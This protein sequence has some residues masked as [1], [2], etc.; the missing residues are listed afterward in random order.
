[1]CSV[2]FSSWSPPQTWNH[3]PPVVFSPGMAILVWR[4]CCWNSAVIRTLRI[5]SLKRIL[6][7]TFR[8]VWIWD[9]HGGFLAVVKLYSYT[10]QKVGLQ[11]VITPATHLYKP[12][13]GLIILLVT[14]KDP[15]CMYVCMYLPGDSSDKM[16][17]IQ[18]VHF[19][20]TCT[21]FLRGAGG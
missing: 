16:M 21:I 18:N 7:A 4:V 17:S 11:H 1:M 3:Q 9:V 2:F 12:Y 13:I 19:Y 6:T 10:H 20:Q 8:S 14:S 5:C 15:P